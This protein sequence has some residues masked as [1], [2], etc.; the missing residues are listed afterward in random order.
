MTLTLEPTRVDTTPVKGPV[1]Y[2]APGQPES[3]VSL[4]PRYE[5]FIGGR[6]VAPLSGQYMTN[7]SPVTGKPFCEVA[8]ST[9]ADVELALDAAHAAKVAWGETSLAD[10][11]AVLN[12]IAD[13]LEAN[14]E[15]L[16][17]AESWENGKPVRETLGADLPLAIDHFRYFAGATRSR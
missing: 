6:W 14:L 15:M 10:R 2:A 3:I 17:V 4:K 11:A 12:R 5:N 7:V 1:P 16:A 8:K 13:A 9:A